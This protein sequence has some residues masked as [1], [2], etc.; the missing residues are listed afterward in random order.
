MTPNQFRKQALALP[1]ATEG[2]HGGHPDFRV[3]GKVFASLGY[4][5]ATFGMVKL[6]PDQQAM[7]VEGTPTVFA[8]IANAWGLKGSWTRKE[9]ELAFAGRQWTDQIL[10]DRNQERSFRP[11]E[12]YGYMPPRRPISTKWNRR[13]TRTRHG[14]QKEGQGP[15][16]PPVRKS[17]QRSILLLRRLRGVTP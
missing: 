7:L 11:P 15:Q 10:G 6:A 13:P 8:P 3:G 2:A 12:S 16:S 14:I 9:T 5:D 17:L 1:D 4:P